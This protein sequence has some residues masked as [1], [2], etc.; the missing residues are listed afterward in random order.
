MSIDC[1]FQSFSEIC[2]CGSVCYILFN[3]TEEHIS[4]IFSPNT[5]P[6]SYIRVFLI[7][8]AVQQSLSC[9]TMHYRSF[10]WNRKLQHTKLGISDH[11][12]W[13]KV[14]ITMHHCCQEKIIFMH[15]QSQTLKVKRLW[16]WPCKLSIQSRQH[17]K[18][19]CN[20]EQ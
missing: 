7:L 14:S 8:Q 2:W 13:R 1:W 5:A 9:N 11:D 19:F 3:F 20:R 16:N 17:W 10:G 12:G 18:H 4:I 15:A 6:D